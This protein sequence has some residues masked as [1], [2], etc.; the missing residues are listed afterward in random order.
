MSQG[1]K[2]PTRKGTKTSDRPPKRQPDQAV[3]IAANDS[4]IQTNTIRIVAEYADQLPHSERGGGGGKKGN[5]VR[6]RTTRTHKYSVLSLALAPNNSHTHQLTFEL[7]H[8]A[9]NHGHAIASADAF[10]ILVV[11]CKIVQRVESLPL[12]RMDGRIATHC[13]DN[14]LNRAILTKLKL[15]RLSPSGEVDDT[16]LQR[17]N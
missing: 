14:G 17:S 7:H 5:E 15:I 10:A 9:H 8:S 6:D 3:C 11:R 12:Y 13:T 2:T 4:T 1:K 16:A